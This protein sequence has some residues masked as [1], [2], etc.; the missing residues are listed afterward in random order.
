VAFEG[1]GVLFASF[2]TGTWVARHDLQ[3]EAGALV[4][5]SF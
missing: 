4:G 5:Y 3:R 1:H 2:A